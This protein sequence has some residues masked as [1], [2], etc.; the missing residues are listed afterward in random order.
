MFPI[1]LYLIMS[2]GGFIIVLSTF[3]AYPFCIISS[4]ALTLVYSGLYFYFTI[5]FVAFFSSISRKTWGSWAVTRLDTAFTYLA[6]YS[7]PPT[8]TSVASLTCYLL[9]SAIF[10]YSK[11][12]LSIVGGD[13]YNTPFF[14]SSRCTF[15]QQGTNN[16]PTYLTNHV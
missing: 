10:L 2:N 5:S 15:A 12:V 13:L 7:F 14:L 8:F 1:L 6:S 11:P 3:F 9:T 4:L 16:T